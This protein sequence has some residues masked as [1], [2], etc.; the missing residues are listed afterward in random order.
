[1]NKPSSPQAPG[2]DTVPSVQA[3]VLGDATPLQPPAEHQPDQAAHS[4]NAREPRPAQD[5]NQPGFTGE[6]NLPHP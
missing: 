4:T 3:D 2:P 1:M 6:R 5:E